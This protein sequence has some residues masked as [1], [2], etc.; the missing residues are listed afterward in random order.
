LQTQSNISIFS[1]TFS[2]YNFQP[3]ADKV[4][5][6]REVTRIERIG[7]LCGAHVCQSRNLTL[8]S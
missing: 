1:E 5:E 2:L 6:I 8:L 3:S 7:K 4:A